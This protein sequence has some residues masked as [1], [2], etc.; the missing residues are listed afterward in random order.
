M[1]GTAV[2]VA[3]AP[4]D[5]LLLR[6]LMDRQ[7]YRPVSGSRRTADRQGK[8]LVGQ[9]EGQA[10]S[11]YTTNSLKHQNPDDFGPA[12][13]NSFSGVAAKSLQSEV[14]Q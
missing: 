4:E 10:A 14:I 5:C 11:W 9:T 1:A 6:R 2:A 12:A 7:N 13:D 8:A 3:A